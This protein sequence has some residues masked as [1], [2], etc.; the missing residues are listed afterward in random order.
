MSSKN[1]K[2]KINYLFYSN[3]I[4]Y[5]DIE[6]GRKLRLYLL[7]NI[8]KNKHLYEDDNLVEGYDYVTCPVL[9][10]RLSMIKKTYISNILYMDVDTFKQKYPE[11]QLICNRRTEN[12]KNGLKEIDEETG[13]TKYQLGRIKSGSYLHKETDKH[14]RRRLCSYD[15][16]NDQISYCEKTRR[17]PDDNDILEVRCTYCSKWFKPLQIYVS[18]RI[19]SLN[20][21]GNGE[22]RLY[23]SDDCK[24]QCPTFNQQRYHRNENRKKY[25]Y[26]VVP[27]AVRH[28]VFERDNWTCQ[29]CGKTDTK[30]NCHHIFPKIDN[31]MTSADID[32]C[33]TYCIDCHKAAHRQPGCSIQELKC[34]K[35]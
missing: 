13:L 17:A 15:T 5:D 1:R 28:M 30:L 27:V 2:C 12:I 35:R 34:D 4:G 3:L 19:R 21:V 25:F 14:F 8:N 32:T 23:C 22:S 26:V 29:K 18:N 7:S 10:I 24:E 31:I 20:K 11:Q 33:I 9:G 16:Y 6:K